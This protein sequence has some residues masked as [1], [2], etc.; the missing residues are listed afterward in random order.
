MSQR[1]AVIMAGGSGTRFWPASRAAHP[2]QFL[3][4]SGGDET[5]L[6]ASVRRAAAVVGATQVLVVTSARHAETTRA[7]LPA[8][9]AENLLL[10]PQGRNTAPCI[11]W[12]IAHARRR[13]PQAVLAVLPADPHVGDEQAFE[14]VLQRALGVAEGGAL[15]TVGITPN[16]PETGYGYVQ[17]GEQCGDGARRVVAFVEKPD[18]ERAEHFFASGDYLWNSGMF[19]F[20]A[21]SMLTAI[22]AHLPQ[23]ARWV[24]ECDEAARRG[25]EEGFVH[26]SYASLPSVSIDY[27]VMERA[28]DILVVPGS[29]GWDD[30]GSWSA[31]W[32]LSQRD[33]DDNGCGGGE[34]LALD[35]SGSYVSAPEGKL[36]ALLGVE[37]LVV[38]DTPDA[39]LVMPRERAQQVRRVL[40]ELKARDKT[41]F[42]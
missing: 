38:V 20:S 28:D 8:L 33:G 19:F 6:Q 29:F 15:V 23:L 40:D 16:R 3:S 36:V 26:D 10:E 13:D 37:D 41:R 34:M 30:V 18:A 39:L 22:E 25:E 24:V 9:P 31:A 21:A 12:A 7:Q 4:L 27:G 11:A 1:F 14:A 5:L 32:Q 2:K 35:A 17:V 42:L